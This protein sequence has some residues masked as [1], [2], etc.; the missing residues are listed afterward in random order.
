MKWEL[1][2]VYLACTTTRD[3]ALVFDSS[4]DN[5]DGIVQTP[6]NFRNELLCPSSQHKRTCLGRRAVFKEIEPL[7]TYLSLL[8]TPASA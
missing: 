8:E 3:N 7:S 2:I 1:G 5:H 6:L 4:L